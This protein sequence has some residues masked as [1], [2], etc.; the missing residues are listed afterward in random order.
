MLQEIMTEYCRSGSREEVMRARQVF[1][2]EI[3]GRSVL[4]NYG[5]MRMY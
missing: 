1:E 3:K 4:A 5:N 2:R